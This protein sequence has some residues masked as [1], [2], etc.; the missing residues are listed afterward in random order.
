MS[1]FVVSK[2]HID[3]MVQAGLTHRPTMS[4]SSS[5]GGP[6]RSSTANGPRSSTPTPTL[7][8]R[9]C[10]PRTSQVSSI[11]TRRLAV[12]PS[13]ARASSRPTTSTCPASTSPRRSRP[14]SSR[15]AF[16]S[17]SAATASRSAAF[18]RCRPSRPE[19]DRLLRVPVLRARRL[20]D[21]RGQAVLRCSPLPHDQPCLPGYSEADWEV[22]S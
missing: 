18:E 21:V 15:S 10:G 5:L 20:G 3:A 9:C 19:G 2:S 13:T 8:A 7:S 1:A 14:A 17:G 12:R 16:P 22:E 6:S 4:A 11:A